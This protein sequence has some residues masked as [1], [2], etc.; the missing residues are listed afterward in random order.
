[1]PV[2]V[3]YG[4]DDWLIPQRKEEFRRLRQDLPNARLTVV[5]DR[6]HY[7]HKDQP[8]K[9]SQLLMEFLAD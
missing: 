1:M 7:L 8:E 3:V 5:P 9:V 6:G 4:E 2:H